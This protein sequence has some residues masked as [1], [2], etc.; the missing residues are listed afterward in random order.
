MTKDN[1]DSFFK[2][3]GTASYDE[4]SGIIRLTEDANGQAGNAY[5]RF[6]IDPREDFAFTGKV[7]VGDKYEGHGSG[8]DGVGFVFH[9][10]NVDKLGQTGVSV[11][12]GGIPG[13]FGF[14]LDTYH[15]TSNPK[16]GQNSIADPKYGKASDKLWEKNAL[17]AFY[18]STNAGKV[19]T[20]GD[21]KPLSPAPSG[22]LVDF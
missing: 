9:T 17:G 18:S 14:K 12:M 4:T 21:A 8:G 6:K 19:N 1:F 13:A 10:G 22:Q 2:E 15:N 7:D 20:I 5:L 16:A 11:G 3:G